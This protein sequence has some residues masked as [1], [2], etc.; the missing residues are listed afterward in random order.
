M[1]SAPHA[2]G[3][4]AGF[5]VLDLS[6]FIAGPSCAQILAD[7]GAEVV[8][9]ERPDGEDARHHEPYYEGESVYTMLYNRNKY[10]ATLD[11]RHPDALGVL[12]QLVRWADVVVE[13][14]RPGTIE[15]MGIGYERMTELKPDIVLTSISG[16]GQTGPLSRRALF[17]AIAQASSGLMDTTGEADGPPT[18]TGTYIADY[19][20]GFQAALGT[21][22]ALMHRE[23]TGEGQ[24]VDVAS[25]DSMF[26]TLG[27]RLISWLMLGSEMPR[28]GSR[29]LLTAPVNV[30]ACADAQMY[31]QAGTNS[32]WPKLCHAIGRDELA[33]D[34]RYRTVPGRMEHVPELEAV[35][36]DW[37]RDR[38]A[39]EIGDVLEEAG[40]PF[41]RVA[42]VPEVAESEQIAAREMVVESEHP[43][44]GTIRMPGNP[45][46]MEKSPPTV[47]KA[48]P[49]V[50]EDND[51]VYRTILGMDD[52]ELERLRSSGAV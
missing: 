46:K 33:T 9:V 17:D 31:I 37:A 15:K 5:R 28:N 20:T 26:A 42:T 21:F 13:N 32:L 12:E 49:T 6:R 35:V 1:Q 41:A 40:I 36:A 16:F 22:A 51:H 4:L 14:Y 2:P 3:P 8:K 11:T 23:R 48:P 25:L 34:E 39:D 50:G 38:T 18:L 7:F 30:Y 44:L 47:R 29:D 19:V 27:T 43:K 10:G 45:I 24:R 52:A